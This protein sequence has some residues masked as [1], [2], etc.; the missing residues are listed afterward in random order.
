VFIILKFGTIQLLRI[1][2]VYPG[3][4]ILIVVHPG[5]RILNPKTATKERD[6][7]KIL[8]SHLFC[9]L[10]STVVEI[11]VFVASDGIESVGLTLLNAV[12]LLPQVEEMDYGVLC[13][14]VAVATDGMSGR[15][16]AKLGVAWQAGGYA[17]E[18]GV[19]SR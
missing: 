16:I 14:E 18:D 11:T 7:K 9:N 4:Q 8:L 13:S 3:S 17:S 6:E 12:L 15:E 10:S 5:S 1:R 19:V 2:D